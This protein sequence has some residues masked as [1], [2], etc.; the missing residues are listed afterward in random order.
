MQAAV[1]KHILCPVDFGEQRTRPSLCRRVCPCSQPGSRCCTRTG[2]SRLPISQGPDRPLMRQCRDCKA[3]RETSHEFADAHFGPDSLEIEAPGG[4]GLSAESIIRTSRESNADLIVMGTHGRSGLNRWTLG[5]VT[6][7]VL[8]ETQIPLLNV[9][10]PMTPPPHRS[11]SITSCARLRHARSAWGTRL[12]NGPRTMFFAR[13]IVLHVR[14]KGGSHGSRTWLPGSG[15]DRAAVN[16]ARATGRERPQ[17]KFVAAASEP[18]C[19]LIVIGAQSAHV[20][21]VKSA[22]NHDRSSGAPRALPSALG[23]LAASE[24]GD[25]S[26][27]A[28]ARGAA[29]ASG[30]WR[31]G[32]IRM[33]HSPSIQN[34]GRASAKRTS[35]FTP[36]LD[37]DTSAPPQAIQD[38][39]A[40]HD[41]AARVILGTFARLCIRCGAGSTKGVLVRRQQSP[42][43]FRESVLHDAGALQ[44]RTVAVL[45][46]PTTIRK[47]RCSHNWRHRPRMPSSPRTTDRRKCWGDA[48]E[49]ESCCRTP[50]SAGCT[51]TF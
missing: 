8:R 38:E 9:R 47:R 15:P 39:I 31:I 2:L 36:P 32:A 18:V 19:D 26:P 11:P 44:S 50:G 49:I 16:C 3:Q 6:E 29:G 30:S 28:G 41:P 20:L 24:R 25:I 4:R 23:S 46:C 42:G 5:S 43:M 1:W 51:R 34:N 48:A 27:K 40:R 10:P 22:G 37:T 35:F 14:G 12:C 7:R 45:R 13:V 21:S 17:G 33:R